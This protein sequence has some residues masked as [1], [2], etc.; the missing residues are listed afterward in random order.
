MSTYYYNLSQFRYPRLSCFLPLV[1]ISL[2]TLIFFLAIKNIC[3]AQ[4]NTPPQ[5]STG[6]NFNAG[7]SSQPWQTIAFAT[8][9]ISGGD[10]LI[11][12]DGTYYNS[13]QENQ[14]S[15]SSGSPRNHTIIK[16]ETEITGPATLNIGGEYYRLTS[17]ITASGTA[18]TINGNNIMFDLDGHTVIYNTSTTSILIHFII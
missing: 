17:D 2:A 9:Q 7:T 16:A 5:P 12:K 13:N 18:F 10:T 11:L 3:S 4:V 1:F 15:P 14:I 8:S 6:S